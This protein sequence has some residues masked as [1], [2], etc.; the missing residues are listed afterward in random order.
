[1]ENK[2]KIVEFWNWCKKCKFN[3]ATDEYGS[4]CDE[5]LKDSVNINSHKPTGFEA[6]ES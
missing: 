2:E 1:M 6:I 5:C 4:E 3:G